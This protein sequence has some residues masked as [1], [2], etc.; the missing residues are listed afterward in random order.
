MK[1]QTRERFSLE[2]ILPVSWEKLESCLPRIHFTVLTYPH[3]TAAMVEAGLAIA[4][5]GGRP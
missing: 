3:V 2:N 4:Q 5:A 1:E